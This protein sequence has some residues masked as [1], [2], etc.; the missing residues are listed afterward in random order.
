M[1]RATEREEEARGLVVWEAVTQE[2]AALEATVQ[3][4]EEGAQELA[5]SWQHE[6]EREM[7]RVGSIGKP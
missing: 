7:G 2:V 3:E 5:V 1:S 6:G 4:W